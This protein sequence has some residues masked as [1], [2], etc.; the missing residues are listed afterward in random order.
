MPVVDFLEPKHR[1]DKDVRLQERIQVA[2]KDYLDRLRERENPKI[3]HAFDREQKPKYRV[4][5]KKVLFSFVKPSSGQCMKKA[6]EADRKQMQR[7]KAYA[8]KEVARVI[9]A[10]EQRSANLTVPAPPPM[11]PTSFDSR[12]VKYQV[13]KRPVTPVDQRDHWIAWRTKTPSTPGK[14]KPLYNPPL[15]KYNK[16][17]YKRSHTPSPPQP[18]AISEEEPP[19]PMTAPGIRVYTPQ[20]RPIAPSP[21]PKTPVVESPIPPSPPAEDIYDQ[22]T[23]PVCDDAASVDVPSVRNVACSPMRPDTTMSVSSEAAREMMLHPRLKP[24]VNSANDYEKQVA[25]NLFKSL[26]GGKSASMARSISANGYQS[27]VPAYERMVK[28]ARPQRGVPTS[29]QYGYDQSELHPHR[30][31]MEDEVVR[32]W[33]QEIEK[34]INERA[35]T[36]QPEFHARPLYQLPVHRQQRPCSRQRLKKPPAKEYTH[37]NS[38]FANASPTGR[39]HFIIAPD[40]VSEGLTIRKLNAQALANR[41]RHPPPGCYAAR[42]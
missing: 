29:T 4:K 25:Y 10:P 18:P 27:P 20:N 32:E 36:P 5:D 13:V 17:R 2:V 6:R 24:W 14:V 8:L 12:N 40:W 42:A 21:P 30:A 26:N 35:K 7:E 3:P 23:V 34:K 15:A 1:V 28:S 19:R 9:N 39:G 41:K 11:K 31:G 38:F 16:T 33:M 37:E 22:S